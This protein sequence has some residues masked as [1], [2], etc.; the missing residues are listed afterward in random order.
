MLY[1]TCSCFCLRKYDK[2]GDYI[3]VAC[4]ENF[5]LKFSRSG[6]ICSASPFFFRG[7]EDESF[8]PF[9]VVLIQF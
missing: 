1:M 5:C 3:V 7:S 2:V 8:F 9:H 4:I 6:V